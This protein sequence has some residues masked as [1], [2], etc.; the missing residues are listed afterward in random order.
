M[1]APTQPED[2]LAQPT[3]GRLFAVLS[4]LHRPAGTDELA[5]Q[6]GLHPNGVRVHLERL[7]DAGLVIRERTRH[8]RG[9]PRDMWLVAPGAMPGGQSPSGY[10][11]LGRWL[12]RAISSR[13]T[14]PRAVEATGRE[15]GHELA[16]AGDGTTDRTLL[17][18]L[19]S[20]GF[21]PRWEDDTPG[22]LTYHLCNCPY[23]DAARESPDVVCGLH[24]GITQGL[25][26]LLEP[27]MRLDTFIAHDPDEAGCLIELAGANH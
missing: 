2:A 17:A 4:K 20:L 16:S 3:R 15:I 22:H 7:R 8:R 25:I 27:E 21:Q 18:V 5:E 1:D 11:D 14:T 23:R 26:D 6:L 19:A 12:A 10:S 9:R 24:R 13:R